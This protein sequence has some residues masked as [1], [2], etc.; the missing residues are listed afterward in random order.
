M[1]M[2]DSTRAETLR[3]GEINNHRHQMLVQY[4]TY[5][6]VRRSRIRAYA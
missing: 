6:N 3:K 5:R 4:I 2:P 1:K